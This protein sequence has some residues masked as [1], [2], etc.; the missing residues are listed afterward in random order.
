MKQLFTTILLFYVAIGTGF[1][2]SFVQSQL[3]R[4]SLSLQVNATTFLTGE[5]LY[6]SIHLKNTTSAKGF[7]GSSIAYVTLVDTNLSE[8]FKHK[9]ALNKGRGHSDFFI[10][11]SVVSGSYKLLAYTHEMLNAKAEQ[12][13]ETDIFI[14]NPYQADQKAIIGASETVSTESECT[15]PETSFQRLA[16]VLDKTQFGTREK[17]NVI[18]QNKIAENGFGKYTI[19]VKKLDKLPAVGKTIRAKNNNSNGSFT[20]ETKGYTYEG[21]LLS[22]SGAPLAN[23]SIGMSV[24]GNDFYFKATVTDALG[25]FQF[26]IPSSIEGTVAYIRPLSSKID[27]FVI[28]PNTQEHIDYSRLTFAKFAIKPE[29]KD[30]LL[31]RSI[32]NQIENAYFS[33]K[34]DTIIPRANKKSFLFYEAGQSTI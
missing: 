1:C 7:K 20:P 3:P 14:I 30:E 9:I 32:A 2:Q 22:K 25:M 10:P 34:P 33:Q 19:S 11:N 28:Q 26:E 21:I 6:Y 15:I 27:S 29:M 31:A 5:Y 23:E 12:F 8:V 17:V 4:E 18:I 16:V 24:P 13:F